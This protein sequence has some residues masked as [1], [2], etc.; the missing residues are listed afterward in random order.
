MTS[1]TCATSAH[2]SV[3]FPTFPCILFF[4]LFLYCICL[5]AVFLC[6]LSIFSLLTIVMSH[7]DGT[8][9]WLSMFLCSNLEVN[10]AK[11][12]LSLSLSLSFGW[13]SPGIRHIF[14]VL[15][16]TCLLHQLRRTTELFEISFRKI[17]SDTLD[18]HTERIWTHLNSHTR[19]TTDLMLRRRTWFPR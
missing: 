6:C 10:D 12:S 15:S 19:P 5:V 9:L 1:S 4:P 16:I 11:I 3:H 13:T 2:Y 17:L 14:V 7:Y 18:C 8:P